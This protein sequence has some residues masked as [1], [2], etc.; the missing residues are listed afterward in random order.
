MAHRFDPVE[1]CCPACE[2]RYQRLKSDTVY[3]EKMR[4]HMEPRDQKAKAA[5][6]SRANK[7]TVNWGS[8]R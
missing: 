1:C 5:I 8:V 6:V 3:V 4:R 2:A 7:E